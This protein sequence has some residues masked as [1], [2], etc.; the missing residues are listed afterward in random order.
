MIL[1]IAAGTKNCCVVDALSK[2][3]N[4]LKVRMILAFLRAG[5]HVARGE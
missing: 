2:L 3:F 5:R 4:M 1:E